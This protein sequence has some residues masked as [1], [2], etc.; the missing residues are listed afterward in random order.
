[1]RQSFF[2]GMGEGERRAAG[3]LVED[4]GSLAFGVGSCA[5][6]L[7]LKEAWPLA[8]GGTVVAAVYGRRAFELGRSAVRSVASRYRESRINDEPV[9][10]E[11]DLVGTIPPDDEAP[12]LE[13]HLVYG[14]P[15][16]GRNSVYFIDLSED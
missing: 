9:I 1:M 6:A 8:L 7:H 15:E 5:V 2:R 10:L 14:E 12:Q 11:D 16:T 3:S 4:I 13:V